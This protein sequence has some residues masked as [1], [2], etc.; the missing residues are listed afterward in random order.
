M[1]RGAC[2]MLP[3]ILLGF[4]S[5]ISEAYHI[6]IVRRTDSNEPTHTEPLI[7]PSAKGEITLF[8]STTNK[9]AADAIIKEKGF[10]LTDYAANFGDFHAFPVRAAYLT[11]S[12]YS[13]AQFACYPAGFEGSQH[14]IKDQ[15]VYIIQFTWEGDTSIEEFPGTTPEWEEFCNYNL[16]FQN[17]PRVEFIKPAGYDE[18]M[19]KTMI[20]GPMKVP[21]SAIDKFRT[22]NFWQY[23]V[24]GRKNPMIPGKYTHSDKLKDP[25]LR[26]AR[27][28]HVRM[29]N[30]L[31]DETYREGQGSHPKFKETLAKIRNKI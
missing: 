10:D 22:P 16:A 3:Y 9:K 21:N 20:T 26:E 7:H 2:V 13:A 8:H 24:L 14:S 31:S 4:Q 29:G 25:I 1:F 28:G 18:I 27:C 15:I 23:A 5:I 19:A 11:D 12:I 17:G 30:Q 6:P